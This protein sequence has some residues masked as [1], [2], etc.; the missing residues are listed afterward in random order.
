M[1]EVR[2]PDALDKNNFYGV[3]QSISAIAFK[4]IEGRDKG[5]D[6]PHFIANWD[7]AARIPPTDVEMLAEE[8]NVSQIFSYNN[9]KE[10]MTE[11]I[12]D[13][14]EIHEQLNIANGIYDADTVIQFQTDHNAMMV[15]YV[16]VK[17]IISTAVS[18]AEVDGAMNS[19][20]WPLAEVV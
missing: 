17:N 8:I 18:V 12:L 11:R 15:E 14:W 13:H 20:N 3:M 5:G 2:K 6:D 9:L 19:I 4:G 10:S 16:R 7:E 1:I